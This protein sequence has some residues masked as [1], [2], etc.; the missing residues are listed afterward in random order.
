MA[1]RQRVTCLSARPFIVDLAYVSFYGVPFDDFILTEFL[2]AK[3]IG[4]LSTSVGQFHVKFGNELGALSATFTD[5]LP[6]FELDSA[7]FAIRFMYR[8][9]H[10]V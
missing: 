6:Q 5:V 7:H 9:T 4:C 10:L 2:N 3:R 1:I 8:F